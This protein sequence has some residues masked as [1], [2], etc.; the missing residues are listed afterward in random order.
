MLRHDREFVAEGAVREADGQIGLE[1]EQAFTD[2]LDD[3]Q[4]GGFAH[5]QLLRTF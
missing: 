2:R 3:I 4:G 5:R 1:H